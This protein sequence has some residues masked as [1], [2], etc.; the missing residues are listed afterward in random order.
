MSDLKRA[1][2]I[3]VFLIVVLRISIGWQFLYEGLWKIENP[4]SAEGYLKS[5]QGPMRDYY[6][7]M[8][9]DPDDLHWLEYDKVSEQW[10]EWIDTFVAHYELDDD[11]KAKLDELVNGKK[12]YYSIKVEK[13]TKWRNSATLGKVIQYNEDTKMLELD[14]KQHLM[15]KEL[16]ALKKFAPLDGVSAEDK[17]RNKRFQ[18]V[19]DRLDK[20]QKRLG[21]REKLRATL[22]G[23]PEVAG[24]VNEEHQGTVDGFRPGSV[25]D[26]TQRVARINK[27]LEEADQDFEHEHLD[28]HRSRLREART[29]SVLRIRGL[30]KEMKDAAVNLL[31]VEQLAKG[32]VPPADTKIARINNQTIWALTILGTMLIL[33][34]GSRLAALAGAGMLFSFYMVQPPWPWLGLPE[35]LGPEHAFIINKNLIEVFALLA[36]ASLPTGTWFGID[37]LIYRCWRKVVAGADNAIPKPAQVPNTAK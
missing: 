23:D 9:D 13:P 5:A 18:D 21:F 10:D 27:M 2:L 29:A 7:G 8:L 25:Y 17:K 1:S 12:T 28:Y 14:G 16:A 32:P 36:I 30:D 33:G 20:E 3:A 24:V 15:P 19:L 11:A 35:G 22:K 4:W 26:Y 31:S 6:R 37:G 34:F